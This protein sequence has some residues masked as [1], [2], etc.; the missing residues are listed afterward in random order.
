MKHGLRARGLGGSVGVLLGSVIMLRSTPASAQAA[1]TQP[2]VTVAVSSE[3]LQLRTQ[4]ME[5]ALARLSKQ[6][7]NSAVLPFFDVLAGLLYCG[8]GVAAAVDKQAVPPGDEGMRGFLATESLALGGM[9]LGVAVFRFTAG[10]TT[11]GHRY[12]RFQRDVHSGRWSELTL[13]QYEGELYADATISARIRRANGWIGLGAGAAGAGLI[14]LG[15]TSRLRGFDRT[16]VYIE[17]GVLLPFGAVG[18]I[19]ALSGQS[20]NEREWRN[21]R[22][23]ERARPSARLTFAPVFTRNSMFVAAGAAF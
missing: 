19:A 22:L 1:L 5:L 20:S 15:A 23:G 10:P 3:S 7:S 12:A 21:Y 8:I 9:L 2:R 18:G 14:A 6:N 16:L 13:S 4:R 17:G 11:D